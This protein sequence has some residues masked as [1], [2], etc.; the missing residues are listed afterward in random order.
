MVLQCDMNWYFFVRF[1]NLRKAIITVSMTSKVFIS[2][3]TYLHEYY[4]VGDF[5]KPI[6]NQGYKPSLKNIT[7]H[8]LRMQIKTFKGC[9]DIF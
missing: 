1:K 7:N 6:K 4:H 8:V 9:F 2:V 3:I 5:T